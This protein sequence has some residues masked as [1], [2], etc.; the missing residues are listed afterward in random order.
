MACKDLLSPIG[1]LL[2]L[3]R[4][5]GNR[6]IN[7]CPQGCTGS[8]WDQEPTTTISDFDLCPRPPPVHP[9]GHHGLTSSGRLPM[10]GKQPLESDS[11]T[12]LFLLAWI[13]PEYSA[14]YRQ[15]KTFPWVKQNKMKS[16]RQQDG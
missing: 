8:Q 16:Y 9:E 6:R 14:N 15:P 10:A 7:L 12:R 2:T 11:Y 4:D 13:S 1:D 3:G 5:G